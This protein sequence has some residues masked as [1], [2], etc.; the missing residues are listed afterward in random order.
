[1]IRPP[2][3]S[4]PSYGQLPDSS[5]SPAAEPTPSP[6]MVRYGPEQHSAANSGTG[7]TRT[8]EPDRRRT[9]SPYRCSRHQRSRCTSCL[10]IPVLL[11]T[12][13]VWDTGPEHRRFPNPDRQDT[14]KHGSRP[15]R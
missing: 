2:I 12:Q 10:G 4:E 7:P 3:G 11:H 15:V 1:V 8:S 5:H 14:P 6:Y 9:W 13:D